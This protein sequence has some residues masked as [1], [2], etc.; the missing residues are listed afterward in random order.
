MTTVDNLCGDLLNWRSLY[1]AGRMHKPLRIIKDNPRVRLTQQ[2]NLASAV[3]TALL[4]L[5]AEFPPAA[6]FARI[7]A[8][9]YTGD[10]RMRLPAENRSKVANIVQR[11]GP[12]FTELYQRLAGALPGV[13]WH[14]PYAR[15]ITQDVSPQARAAHLRK[16]PSNLLARVERHY[17]GTGLP[18]RED[19]EAV[20]WTKMA[21]DEKLP[22]VLEQGA[23]AFYSST[24]VAVTN[25]ACM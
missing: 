23:S 15:T 11:Q 7:A 5:P 25:G 8:I 22:S 6:L 9:S 17:A 12:Q 18:A 3:R 1:L 13:H 21:A 2:V 20:Y 24:N 10:P 16:L 19:D 14:T 4:S